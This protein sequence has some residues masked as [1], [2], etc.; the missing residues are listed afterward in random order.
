MKLSRMSIFSR[1]CKKNLK[2]NL[3]VVV[4]LILES[5]TGLEITATDNG[6]TDCGVDQ[7][8][9]CLTSDV[10]RSHLIVLKIKISMLFSCFS[11]YQYMCVASCCVL[12]NSDLKSWVKCNQNSCLQFAH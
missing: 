12:R 4:V 8:T 7:S 5:K 9:F 10:D 6:W 3:V 11:C 1:I 2:S